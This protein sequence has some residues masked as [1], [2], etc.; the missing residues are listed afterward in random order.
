MR[1]F[2]ALALVIAAIPAAAAFVPLLA[3]AAQ[4]AM[5]CHGGA[6][7]P[8]A[9]CCLLGGDAGAT[10][11]SCPGS[12]D[13]VPPAPVCRMYPPNPSAVLERPS[14]ARPVETA[15]SVARLLR[16]AEPPDPVPLALS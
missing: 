3:G 1:R 2:C 7:A 4:C 6:S 16:P 5:A 12:R 14:N 9:T 11:S 13:G 8:A 15:D 10:L